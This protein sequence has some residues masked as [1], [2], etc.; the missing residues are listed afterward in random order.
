[1]LLDGLMGNALQVLRYRQE[2]YSQINHPLAHPLFDWVVCQTAAR[3]RTV[4]QEPCD[5][6]IYE[7]LM[8]M[9]LLQANISRFAIL[10]KEQRK[11]VCM[12][13]AEYTNTLRQ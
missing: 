8:R 11:K 1:M 13:F 4:T 5:T 10:P 9:Q 6:D 2:G 7:V 3:Q 12:R